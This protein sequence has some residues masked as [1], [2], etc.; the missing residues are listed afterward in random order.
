MCEHPRLVMSLNEM[1]VV[2]HYLEKYLVVIF[3]S[4]LAYL[5]SSLFHLLE[6]V[7]FFLRRLIS[8]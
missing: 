6:M 8:I 3:T 1:A 4:S 7:T 2:F 5:G